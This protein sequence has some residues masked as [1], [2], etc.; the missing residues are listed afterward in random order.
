MK[1]LKGTVR[2][3][4]G[5]NTL[6]ALTRVAGHMEWDAVLMM[7]A[8]K[9]SC[10]LPEGWFCHRKGGAP[11]NW[12]LSSI[13]DSPEVTAHTSVSL[14]TLRPAETKRAPHQLS[15]WTLQHL[16]RGGRLLLLT[17]LREVTWALEVCG[18]VG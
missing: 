11:Q 18:G 6:G 10:L 7:A 4:V 12:G 1:S 14:C 8:G 17:E 5:G 9:L 16:S 13:L 15:K 3:Q 2:D